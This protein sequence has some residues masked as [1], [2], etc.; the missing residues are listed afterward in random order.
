ME[1]IESKARKH[2]RDFIEDVFDDEVQRNKAIP[3]SDEEIALDT[4]SEGTL[5]LEG[6]WHFV[7]Q[8]ACILKKVT[9]LIQK[10]LLVVQAIG[11]ITFVMSFS[12]ILLEIQSTLKTPPSQKTTMKKSST[13]VVIITACF[14]LLCGGF[15]YDAFVDLTP[16]NLLIGFGFYEPYWLVDFDGMQKSSRKPIA[17]GYSEFEGVV[18]A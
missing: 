4:G 11:D 15:G 13:I 8:L 1:N 12:L 17:T 7:K 14:Y 18:I 5:S 2:I 9:N 16:G 3:L 10:V 6:P